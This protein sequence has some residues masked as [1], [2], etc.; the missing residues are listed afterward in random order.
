MEKVSH[1]ASLVVIIFTLVSIV[2]LIILRYSYFGNNIRYGPALLKNEVVRGYPL[3]QNCA[4]LRTEEEVEDSFW[5]LQDLTAG[6]NKMEGW[7]FRNKKETQP[8]FGGLNLT[9]KL[10]VPFIANKDNSDLEFSLSFWLY[11]EDGPETAP[12]RRP[13]STII[14]CPG[15]LPPLMSSF[16]IEYSPGQGPCAENQ[17]C[18]SSNQIRIGISTNS[19]RGESE[20]E[21]DSGATMRKYSIPDIPIQRWLNIVLSLDGR[22][23]DFY[24]NGELARSFL[25]DQVPRIS[26]DS[27]VLFPQYGT[28]PCYAKVTCVRFFSS[29]LGVQQIRDIYNYQGSQPNPPR[30]GPF[31]WMI[32]ARPV[33]PPK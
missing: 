23:Y 29:L 10:G 6:F 2:T 32:P 19:P 22:N 26:Y 12:N 14:D 11:L 1:I 17:L 21:Y 3:N 28:F 18:A 31:W 33:S 20:S 7:L 15:H 30:F 13:W 24:L 25:I 16:M 4:V 8:P 5:M 27:L 9:R